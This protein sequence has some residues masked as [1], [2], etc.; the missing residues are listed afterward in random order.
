MKTI[1]PQYRTVP[2]DTATAMR[3]AK[4]AAVTTDNEIPLPPRGAYANT[5]IGRAA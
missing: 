3:T 4:A 1:K 5:G 2:E